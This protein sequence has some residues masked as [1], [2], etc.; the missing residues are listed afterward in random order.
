MTNPPVR[1]WY[2]SSR[3]ETSNQCVEVRH[4]PDATLVRDTKDNGTGPILR[5]APEAWTDFVDSR[6]WE[7]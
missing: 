4:D 2:K 7:R 5:F 6:V 1:Q 3:S